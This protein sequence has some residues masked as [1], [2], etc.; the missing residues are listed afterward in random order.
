MS[1]AVLPHCWYLYELRYNVNKIWYVRG[2]LWK[3]ENVGP[4]RLGTH[5]YTE[6]SNIK[7]FSQTSSSAMPYLGNSTVDEADPHGGKFADVLDEE[8]KL[9]HNLLLQADFWHEYYENLENRKIGVDARGKIHNPEIFQALA[10]GYKID[11]SD[12]TMTYDP[13]NEFSKSQ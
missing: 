12:C 5:T 13:E 6:L 8:G 4:Y 7:L 3:L 1:L 2:G 11:D 10:Q 9:S